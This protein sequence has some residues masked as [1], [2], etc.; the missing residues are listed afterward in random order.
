MREMASQVTVGQCRADC[1]RNADHFGASGAGPGGSAVGTPRISGSIMPEARSM[2][3]TVKMA[4]RFGQSNRSFRRVVRQAKCGQSPRTLALFKMVD[5]PSF[6]LALAILLH[7]ADGSE[8]AATV[9]RRWK[10][11]RDEK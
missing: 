10:L 6:P 3:E 2:P 1:R 4:P 7:S 5:Q 11:S 9:S 8:P